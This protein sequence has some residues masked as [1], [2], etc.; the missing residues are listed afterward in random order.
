M[1]I[2]SPRSIVGAVVGLLALGGVRGLTAQQE[3][4]AATSD[5]GVLGQ[6]RDTS[7]TVKPGPGKAPDSSMT[8]PDTSRGM[9]TGQVTLP[10]YVLPRPD[11]GMYAPPRSDSGTYAPPDSATYA[12]PRSDS[13]TYAPPRSTSTRPPDE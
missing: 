13:G 5:T 6:P 8:S 9:G 2:Y 1:R 4:G 12:P 11:S 10:T 7:V 3:T